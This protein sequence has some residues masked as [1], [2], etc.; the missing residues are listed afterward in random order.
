MIYRSPEFPDFFFIGHHIIIPDSKHFISWFV[1]SNK[2]TF[3]Y[4][5]KIELW[6][7]K[8]LKFLHWM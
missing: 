1:L 7:K 4:I 2:S 5:I 6:E 8:E 3:I